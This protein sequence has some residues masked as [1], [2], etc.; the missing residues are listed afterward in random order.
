M[1]ISRPVLIPTLLLV[2]LIVL[3]V[4]GF[5]DFQNGRTSAFQYFGTIAVTL[6]I[7]VLLHFSLKRRERLRNQ[8]RADLENSNNSLNN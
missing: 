6:A 4:I 7:I 2:Y 5:A 8:R 1:K 3:A